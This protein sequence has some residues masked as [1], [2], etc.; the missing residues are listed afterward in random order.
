MGFPTLV[1]ARAFGSLWDCIIFHLQDHAAV[2]PQHSTGE[3]MRSWKWWHGP[4]LI[5]YYHLT[6]IIKADWEEILLARPLSCPLLCRA[7]GMQLPA[8]HQ[9]CQQQNHWAPRGDDP[10]HEAARDAIVVISLSHVFEERVSR[11]TP[12]FNLNEFCDPQLLCVHA[13]WSA[14]LRMYICMLCS[15]KN[16]END[17]LHDFSLTSVCCYLRFFIFFFFFYSECH[18]K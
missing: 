8:G 4:A 11:N 9:H 13:L 3:F 15:Y 10:L 1:A 5:T 2:Q 16:P 14:N 6:I 17:S 7:H 12:K 18:W